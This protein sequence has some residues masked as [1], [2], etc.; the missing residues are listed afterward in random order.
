MRR[1]ISGLQAVKNSKTLQRS[2]AG[3]GV[4][5][6]AR[7]IDVQVLDS[8]GE[9]SSSDILH[10]VQW[11]MKQ[12]QKRPTRKAIINISFVSVRPLENAPI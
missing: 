3:F 9:A 10:G 7:L 11:I 8:A 5:K 6:K 1:A 2:L 4:T 12:I